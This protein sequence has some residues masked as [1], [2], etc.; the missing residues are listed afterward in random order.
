MVSC[1]VAPPLDRHNQFSVLVS[2]PLSSRRQKACRLHPAFL[3]ASWSKLHNMKEKSQQRGWVPS[4]PLTLGRATSASTP[5]K[6][7]PTRR[8]ASQSPNPILA[9]DKQSPS[10]KQMMNS[11]HQPTVSPD[12]FL[13]IGLFGLEYIPPHL[14][15]LYKKK[16][17][18]DGLDI[19]GDGTEHQMRHPA[20]PS[21]AQLW[22]MHYCSEE[23][24]NSEYD[25]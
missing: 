10:N 24:E 18:T 19:T 3:S 2:Q 5:K 22:E 8:R 20:L 4:P 15:V 21:K 23:L 6:K 1:L 9:Q 17:S 12:H 16:L 11:S 13:G 14:W 25:N 7:I